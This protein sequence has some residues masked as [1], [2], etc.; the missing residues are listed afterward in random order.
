MRRVVLSL[1]LTAMLFASAT[2]YAAG[3]KIAGKVKAEGSAEEIVVYVEN[4]SG[5][6][7]SKTDQPKMTQKNTSFAPG[8]LI[9]KKGQKVEFPNEDK[10]HH[11][12]FSVTPG[13]TFDLGMYR[14]GESK[15]VEMKAAGETDVYCNIH[16]EMKAKILVLQNDYF[17]K[18]G[19]DGSFTIDGVPPG[20]YSVVAWSTKHQPQ[21]IQVSVKDGASSPASF[22]LAERKGGK[23]LN[24]DGA[25][26]GRYK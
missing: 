22:S 11:N 17:A 2:A 3:G 16:P 4:V 8:S 7:A 21:K 15:T 10:F 24:K 13:N 19:K 6:S 14:A 9:V 5:A 20:D 26:Y 1:S 25:Q 18:V 23:H 12:V